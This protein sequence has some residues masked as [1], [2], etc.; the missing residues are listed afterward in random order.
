MTRATASTPPR[1]TRLPRLSD[2]VRISARRSMSS[3]RLVLNILP[4]EGW[5]HCKCRGQ[6]D[7]VCSEKSLARLTPTA[8]HG[9]LHWHCLRERPD[10]RLWVDT[11]RPGLLLCLRNL[12][13]WALE[14][15]RMGAGRSG[16]PNRPER[17]GANAR[18][19]AIAAAAGGCSS[20][21][22]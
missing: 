18:P 2:P 13:R 8:T 16:D 21:S 15:Q 19:G 6:C 17:R 4:E 11:S 20:S 14:L 9:P 12:G 7:K 1:R 22:R 5:P 10:D 3:S